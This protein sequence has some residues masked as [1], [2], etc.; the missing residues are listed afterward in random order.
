METNHNP[1]FD[2]VTPNMDEIQYVHNFTEQF[3][4]MVDKDP[5]KA[6]KIVHEV[7]RPYMA[8]QLRTIALLEEQVE[9]FEDQ[10][11]LLL[12][13]NARL[14]HNCKERDVPMPNFDQIERDYR[15]EKK[16]KAL[17]NKGTGIII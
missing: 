8:A 16:Q 9:G 12:R 1:L 15:E 13:S 4:S 17:A 6:K 14:I 3:L 11:T 2:S 5:Q 7:L 10:N